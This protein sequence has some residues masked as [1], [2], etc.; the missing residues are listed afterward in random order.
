MVISLNKIILII[1]G[2]QKELR[3]V[4]AVLSSSF[5]ENTPEKKYKVVD[6]SKLTIKASK[7]RIVSEKRTLC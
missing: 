1:Y 4:T 6:D 2:I 3:K 5:L 7:E